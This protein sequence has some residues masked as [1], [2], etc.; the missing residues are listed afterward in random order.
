MR[1]YLLKQ[2]RLLHINPFWIP[3][4][5]FLLFGLQYY[6]PN[7]GGTG[8]DLPINLVGWLFIGLSLSFGLWQFYT[9]GILKFNNQILIIG[10][11][12]FVLYIPFLYGK[13]T[14]Q[15]STW[16]RFLG[17]PLIYLFLLFSL[18]F[19]TTEKTK[20]ITLSVIAISACFQLLIGIYQYY[21]PA[22]PF[23]PFG[24]FQQ[25]NLMSSYLITGYASMLYLSANCFSLSQIKT[26]TVILL[27][28]L[29]SCLTGVMTVELGSR[30]AQI[31][32][33]LVSLFTLV[34]S[35][36][37]KKRVPILLILSFLVS[38]F[39]HYLVTSNNSDEQTVNQSAFSQFQQ[40]YDREILYPQTIELISKNLMTGVGYGNFESAYTL[41]SA[42]IAKQENNPDL[43]RHN[44]SHPHNEGLFWFAEGGIIAGISVLSLLALLF[45]WLIQSGHPKY[46]L[47]LGLFT[48]LG[49]H[50][51]IEY[52]LHAS[53]AHLIVLLLLT[54]LFILNN[55][56]KKRLIPNLIVPLFRPLS[57][58]TAI[59]IPAFCFTGLH[60]ISLVLNYEQKGATSPEAY[61][62]IINPLV[63]YD[64]YW[65]NI[66]AH[67]AIVAANNH[68][69]KGMRD[70]VSWAEQAI[71]HHPKQ[72]YFENII[73]IKNYLGELK[74][75]DCEKYELYFPK[76]RCAALTHLQQN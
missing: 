69:I 44:M 72:S 30:G 41:H 43:V 42:Q 66:M 40:D 21:S 29:F 13:S 68:D 45:L 52:P 48:P 76:Q 47:I 6:Q 7:M 24:H 34:Y 16:Y 28:I 2:L 58:I 67:K 51:L 56:I 61:L 59:L 14:P 53:L 57:V 20:I 10:G 8:T 39:G 75:E 27:F 17:L 70:Y 4:F 65:S 35:I 33:L 12:L 55:K 37:Q 46:W 26:K 62:H 54:R 1:Q 23:P 73:R 71:Q 9:R 11:C 25:K 49:I 63:H 38:F 22:H 19:R 3:T 31:S 5:L 36:K 64:R 18:Q 50:T 32:A 15:I 60:T 74:K